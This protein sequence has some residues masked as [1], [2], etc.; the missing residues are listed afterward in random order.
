MKAPGLGSVVL[1]Q[2]Q[3]YDFGLGFALDPSTVSNIE[4]CYLLP[5]MKDIDEWSCCVA[6]MQRSKLGSHDDLLEDFEDHLDRLEV[7]CTAIQV[8]LAIARRRL[9]S[10]K[11]KE[12]S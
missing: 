9:E 7:R 10:R 5:L 1:T 12:N 8:R 2:P 4:P 6:Q 11:P 3:N